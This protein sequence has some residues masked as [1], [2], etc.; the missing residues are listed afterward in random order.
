MAS[1]TAPAFAGEG[2]PAVGTVVRDFRD[3]AAWP[4]TLGRE[5]LLGLASYAVFAGGL[6]ANKREVN[7]GVQSLLDWDEGTREGSL[8]GF[9]FLGDHGVVA[10][11]GALL[12]VSGLE[13]GSPREVETGVMILESYAFT[14]LFTLAGQFILSEER[15]R[16]GGTMGFF[17]PDG[18]GVSGHA[19]LAASLV[20]PV[21]RQ[22]LGRNSGDG[23]LAT[24][25]K[26]VAR[27][28]LWTMPFLTGISRIESNDHYAWNV[29]LGLSIGYGTGHLV[30]R[31]HEIARQ[32][33]EGE[34]G[35][36][37]TLFEANKRRIVWHPAGVSYLF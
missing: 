11:A 30:A 36:S 25:G 37:G 1:H 9:K 35:G 4:L 31:S 23:R 33:C 21:S 5:N 3:V 18:H 20:G 13:L 22:Y 27:I 17:K 6:Y 12:V 28:A 8:Q 10:G 16:D 34:V 29:L 15:P 2:D 19:A 24:L 32:A 7:E 14:G 26:Q